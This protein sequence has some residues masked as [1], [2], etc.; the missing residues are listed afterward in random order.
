[1][2]GKLAK[3]VNTTISELYTFLV[4]VLLMGIVKKPTLRDYWSTD[5]MLMT[6]F[7]TTLFS[8]DRWL[9]LLRV[10]HFV[11]NTTAHIMDPLY[12]IRPVL[13][14]LT[15]AFGRVFTPHKDL[16]VD[17]SLMLWK[18][19]LSFKQYIPS[20]RNR[21]G[22]KFFILCDVATGFV[23]DLIV[24]TGASTDITLVE[25]LG[26]SG[27]VVATLLQKYLG[28]GRV[29]YVD[30]WYSSPTLF[31]F[32]LDHQTGACGTVR[33]NR[34][35]MPTFRSR[36]SRGEV[37]F[38][39]NG[40]MLAVKWHD[41]RDVHVLST[42]HTSTMSETGKVDHVTGELRRKP[43]C[44]LEYNLK[45]GAVDK[46]DMQNSFVE[47]A[48]KSLK[49]YKKLYFHLMDIALLNAYIVYKELTGRS[50]KYQQFRLNV[51][52]QLLEEHHTPRRPPTGGRPSMDNP[53]RL[54]AR[55]FPTEIPQTGLQGKNTR[56]ACKVCKHTTRRQKK[57]QYTRYMCLPCDT[58]LCPAPCFAEYHTHKHY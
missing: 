26:V 51:M 31:N 11:P 23:Q 32:L 9:L 25:G 18:G 57:K 34:R 28:K 49:W 56:R 46:T 33:P 53:L 27:S 22:V 38:R 41:K 5:P 20:K 45:M 50:I 15:K 36:M 6:P 17:E 43:D 37:E 40:D 1:M 4:A 39:Q 16:C 7:F 13:T 44:V 8:Q 3:W 12:K 24:Y 2:T 10:L 42:V 58:P 14:S 35:G 48:R 47:C 21:F 55:H 30:N 54:T 29:L 52:R 19:R